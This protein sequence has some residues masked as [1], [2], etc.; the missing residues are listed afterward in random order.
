MV[1]DSFE[2]LLQARPD[3]VVCSGCGEPGAAW[4][5]ANATTPSG[6]WEIEG[7]AAM[8]L[9]EA[10]GPGDRSPRPALGLA[11]FFSLGLANRS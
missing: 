11:L 9:P 6:V 8:P 2:G 4:L 10:A 1:I 3:R 5:G 7:T